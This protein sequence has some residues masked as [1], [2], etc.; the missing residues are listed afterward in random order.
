MLRCFVL[1][2]NVKGASRAARTVNLGEGFRA[3]FPRIVVDTSASAWTQIEQDF[4]CDITSPR[5]QGR[6]CCKKHLSSGNLDMCKGTLTQSRIVPKS[7]N[8]GRLFWTCSN[9]F[10]LPE[11]H[12][13][14]SPIPPNCPESS[15]IVPNRP[16]LSRMYHSG[17]N[18][19][20]FL[21]V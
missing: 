21:T 6:F 14:C 13:A 2:L 10:D 8:T 7:L 19:E 20:L 3:S 18:T 9:I 17:R 15:R 16:E 5:R 1:G 4:R 12:F 11:F